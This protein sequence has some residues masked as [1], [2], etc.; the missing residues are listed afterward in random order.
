MSN[1]AK[2][3]IVALDIMRKNYLFF[4]L[5]AE[6]HLNVSIANRE[7]QKRENK[8]VKIMTNKMKI[9]V[10]IAMVK[11]IGVVLVVASC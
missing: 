1:L 10:I 6:I 9:Y 3:E 11:F 7:R 4:I 8:K 5:D 2:F